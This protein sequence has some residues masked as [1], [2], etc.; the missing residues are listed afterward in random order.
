MTKIKQGFL[1]Q[2]ACT[3]INSNPQFAE[4]VNGIAVKF[5]ENAHLAGLDLGGLDLSPPA[6]YKLTLSKKQQ[7]DLR[8]ISTTI[9]CEDYPRIKQD[10]LES[11][12]DI[13]SDLD[14]NLGSEWRKDM[15]GRVFGKDGVSNMPAAKLVGI[16]ASDN[17]A[18]RCISTVNSISCPQ[19]WGKFIDCINENIDYQ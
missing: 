2:D 9:S 11:L 4:L 17:F 5:L 6:K 13:L 10:L 3:L 18:V 14:A 8:E 19:L 7:G 1:S 16:I 12:S 15:L